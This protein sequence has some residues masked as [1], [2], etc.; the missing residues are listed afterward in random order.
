M[1]MSLNVSLKNIHLLK[2]QVQNE[3]PVAFLSIRKRV[4]IGFIQHTQ[5][6]AGMVTVSF[7]YG[8]TLTG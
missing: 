2:A 4:N 5:S 6:S 8:Q 1:S 7:I 3:K